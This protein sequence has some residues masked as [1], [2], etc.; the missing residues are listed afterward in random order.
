M[1]ALLRPHIK[2]NAIADYYN[3]PK[4]KEFANAQIQKILITSWSP[5]GFATIIEETRN[6]TGD[7]ALLSI[8]STS[9]AVHIEDLLKANENIVPDNFAN[10][11]I[12]NLSSTIIVAKAMLNQRISTLEQELATQREIANAA[13]AAQQSVVNYPRS[14]SLLQSTTACRNCHQEFGC[15]IEDHGY[16][17]LRCAHCRCRHPRSLIK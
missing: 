7:K 5:D 17:M 8:L 12:R 4:L 13:N 11:V 1:A 3:I 15:Y 9:A 10:D 2:V 16:V 6:S 14:I